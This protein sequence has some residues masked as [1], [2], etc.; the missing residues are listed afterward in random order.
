MRRSALAASVVLT[1]ATVVSSF[2]AG[3]AS[4][5]QAPATAGTPCT[6]AQT[7]QISSLI[8][9]PPAVHA[10]GS[11]TASANVVNCT[12]VAQKAS[13]QWMGRFVSA[14]GTGFP[15]GCPVIDP[16]ILPVNLPPYGS[17]TSSVGYTV[18]SSCTANELVV[19][20]EILQQGKIVAQAASQLGWTASTRW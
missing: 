20:V 4:A 1:C 16:L 8:F 9:S 19:T 6:S 13:A 17:A 7:I 18:P 3:A 12:A 15:A 2:G 5:A 14:S 10:G 11:S